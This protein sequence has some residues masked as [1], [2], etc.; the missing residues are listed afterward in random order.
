MR[1]LYLLIFTFTVFS[2]AQIRISYS[3]SEKQNYE[4]LVWDMNLDIID[5]KTTFYNADFLDDKYIK[6][7]PNTSLLQ[8]LLRKTSDTNNELFVGYSTN[9]IF[10][11]KSNDMLKW[12]LTNEQKKDNDYTLQKAT[13]SFAGRNWIAWFCRDFPFSEGPFKFNGLPG[14]IFEVKDREDL[15]SFQLTEIKKIT[16]DDKI[17]F[18]FTRSI[19]TSLGQN[20]TEYF[21]TCLKCRL[22]EIKAL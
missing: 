21:T 7:T 20:L 18:F 16:K 1:I 19:L 11:I 13:T 5:G 2:F 22:K 9:E 6:Y 17:S 12:T 15:F 10:K 4:T 3:F 14:L 8:I